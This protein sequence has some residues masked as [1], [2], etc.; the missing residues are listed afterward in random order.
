MIDNLKLNSNNRQLNDLAFK[1][2]LTFFKT[3]AKEVG[4]VFKQHEIV[5]N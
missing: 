1:V 4:N 3:L 2:V 5:G